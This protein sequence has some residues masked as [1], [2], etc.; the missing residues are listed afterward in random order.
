MIMK[1]ECILF[2]GGGQVEVGTLDEREDEEAGGAPVPGRHGYGH[3]VVAVLPH[4][5]H[6]GQPVGRHLQ[7]QYCYEREVELFFLTSPHLDPGPE[8][9]SAARSRTGQSVRAG[10]G[11]RP[12]NLRARHRDIVISL[13]W[14]LCDNY[15]KLR[16]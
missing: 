2:T 10:A 15:I 7:P 12:S 13:G 9:R 8:S 5:Q 16:S 6:H 3:L 11:A 1:V 4:Q 14:N